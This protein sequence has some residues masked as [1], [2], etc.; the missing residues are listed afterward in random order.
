MPISMFLKANVQRL[1]FYQKLYGLNSLS[2]P[3]VVASLSTPRDCST[4]HRGNAR[5]PLYLNARDDDM[6][7]RCVIPRVYDWNMS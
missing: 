6:V 3:S 4:T 1:W 7:W 2:V 5:V